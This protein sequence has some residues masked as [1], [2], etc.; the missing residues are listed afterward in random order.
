MSH[1]TPPHLTRIAL[2]SALLL[3]MAA[4]AP[5]CQDDTAQS[6]LAVVKMDLAGKPFNLELANTDPKRKRGLM[7][8]ESMPADHGMIFVFPEQQRLAFWMKNTKIPLDLI[9][10]NTD[11][12][13]VSIHP[14]EPFETKSV[15]SDGPALYAIELNRGT[16]EKLKLKPGDTIKVHADA[17]KAADA[18]NAD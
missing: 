7:Y 12:K 5:G 8:R 4:T 1:P 15:P 9:Y 17:R 2:F 18:E 3:Y 6:N 10:I 16:A 13:I 14:L 11:F